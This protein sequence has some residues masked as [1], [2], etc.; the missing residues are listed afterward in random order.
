[1]DEVYLK[2]YPW[3]CFTFFE[4]LQ[5]NTK[6]QQLSGAKTQQQQLGEEQQ[7]L[8]GAKAQQQLGEE[9]LRQS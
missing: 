5:K 2:K 3:G 4:E 9:P 6:P 7:Q 8:S 1:L